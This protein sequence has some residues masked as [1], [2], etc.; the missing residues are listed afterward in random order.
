MCSKVIKCDKEKCQLP[1]APADPWRG[2]TTEIPH[3]GSLVGPKP[4]KYT[5]IEKK[6][7]LP[8]VIMGI[9]CTL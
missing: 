2:L 1:L 9:L 4:K 3:Q 6:I 8:H 5:Q 7:Q